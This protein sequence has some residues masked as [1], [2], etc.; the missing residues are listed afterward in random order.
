M[1]HDNRRYPGTAS[2]LSYTSS[3]LLAISIAL[4]QSLSP[5]FFFNDTATTEIYTLSLHD[6]LPISRHGAA[7]SFIAACAVAI[8]GPARQS[9]RAASID[10]RALVRITLARN[11]VGIA[12][13]SGLYFVQRS[14]HRGRC[15][16]A[17]GDVSDFHVILRPLRLVRRYV[18]FHLVKSGIQFHRLGF[19]RPKLRR[20][21][22]RRQE[23][24]RLLRV[25]LR[26][27]RIDRLWLRRLNFG[28]DLRSGRRDRDFRDRLH[29]LHNLKFQGRLHVLREDHWNQKQKYQD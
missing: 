19:Y 26:R 4:L 29:Q 22:L 3:G 9:W 13:S 16:A 24:V 8:A 23:D 14:N 10:V 27:F 25:Q 20:L 1:A 5:F 7:N 6:A 2:R 18:N 28:L 11:S 17:R 21:R 12:E 15:G